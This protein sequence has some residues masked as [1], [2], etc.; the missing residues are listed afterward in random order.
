MDAFK[1][2]LAAIDFSSG[3]TSALALAA[4]MARASDAEL[5]LLHV[6]ALGFSVELPAATA[7]LD[8]ESRARILRALEKLAHP[9]RDRVGGVNIVVREGDPATEIAA[10]AEAHGVDLVALGTHGRRGIDRLI[11]GSVAEHV[12]RLVHC[13]VLAVHQPPSEGALKSSGGLRSILCPLDLSDTSEETLRRALALAETTRAK[14]T[15][16]H[17][18]DAWHWEDPWPIARVNDDETRRRLF[19]SAHERLSRL[20]AAANRRAARIETVITFGRPTSEILRVS[21]SCNADAIVLGVH[22]RT[23]MDRFFFGSTAQAVLRGGAGA[24]LLVR[25][26]IARGKAAEDSEREH[27]KA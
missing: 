23:A 3:S 10:F 14:V 7:P 2:V 26:P 20:L 27:A 13:S 19:Q 5:T 6:H 15:V 1:H 9:W 18:I 16:M 24:I 4:D 21:R 22:S 17:A 25:V 12:S 11:L 8:G